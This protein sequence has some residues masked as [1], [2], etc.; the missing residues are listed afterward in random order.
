M[1]SLVVDSSSGGTGSGG[2]TEDIIARSGSD[3][4]VTWVDTV[5]FV[6]NTITH[7]LIGFVFIYTIWVCWK[8][9][10]EQIFAW[11]VVLCMTGV[12]DD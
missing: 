9:G 11:H 1:K 8:Y 12:S 5:K 4:K 10:L 6:V 3:A 7:V 2:S